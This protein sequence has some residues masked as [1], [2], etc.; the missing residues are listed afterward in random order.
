MAAINLDFHNTKLH[1]TVTSTSASDMNNMIHLTWVFG[2][3]TVAPTSRGLSL[4]DDSENLYSGS[5]F[6]AIQ[7]LRS[8]NDY[9]LYYILN[10]DRQSFTDTNGQELM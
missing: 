6:S 3:Y 4:S 2:E 9:E 10:T 7:N 5:I 8:D 1:M